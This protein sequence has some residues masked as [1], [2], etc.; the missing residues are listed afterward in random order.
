MDSQV[1]HYEF[2]L[3]TSLIFTNI[4]I[5]VHLLIPYMYLNCIPVLSIE[6]AV[7]FIHIVEEHW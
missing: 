6:K 2:P 7:T 1:F 3:I 5:K 4:I